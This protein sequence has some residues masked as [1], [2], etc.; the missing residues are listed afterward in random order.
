[1]VDE[2]DEREDDELAREL[3]ALYERLDPAPLGDDADAAD[4]ETRRVVQWM[5]AS[6]TELAPRSAPPVPARRSRGARLVRLRPWVRLAL[7]A[8]L[9]AALTALVLW[10]RR[11]QRAPLADGAPSVAAP[12]APSL[13][14][15]AAS[16]GQVELRSG[17]V[18]LVLIEPAGSS[19]PHSGS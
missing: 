17:N 6:W 7:A 9:L 5:R 1:M 12:T 15:L 10:T 11:P 3:R 13:E 8:M 19:G 18:R 16:P 14:L 4:P 2:R